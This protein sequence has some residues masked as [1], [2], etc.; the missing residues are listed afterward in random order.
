MIKF[1]FKTAWR[2]LVKNGVY[3]FINITGLATGLAVAMLVGLWIWDELSFNAY[4]QHHSRLAQVLLN[5]TANGETST[6]ETISMP[7]GEALRTLHAGD[8]KYVSLTSWNNEHT[9]SVENNKLPVAGRWVEPDF[10]EMFTLEM[11]N[12][13]RGV[14]K[15][16]STILIAESMAKALFGEENPINRTVRLD[17]KLDLKIG[18]VY[19]DLPHNSSFNDTKILLPWGNTENW[20]NKQTSWSN[21]CGLLYVLLNENTDYA[22]TN[23]KIKNIP[24]PH[25][26]KVKEEIMLHPFSKLNL[27]TE[28]ENGVATGGRI[29]FVWLFGI[30]GMFVLLLACINFINLSTARSEKRA[31]E[32][33][34]KKAVGSLRSQ[35]IS[36]FLWEAV[37]F[38]LIAF[39]LAL[40][41]V[42]LSLPY[43]NTLADKQIYLVSI[44]PW[45]LLLAL[46]VTILTGIVSGSYPA[47]YLSRFEPI[48]VLKGVF[49][50]G[51][52]ASLPRKVLVVVQFTVSVSLIIGT[53]VIFRQ[54][55]YA[56]DRPTGFSRAGLISIPLTEGLY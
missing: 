21:H 13:N 39:L 5:Q 55:E 40:V 51:R 49:T 42:Q 26:E 56:K 17:N 22:S 15:D 1:F 7:L 31:K 52:F 47:F 28:F 34:I 20:M 9:I 53:I 6:D 41:F 45:F 48:K 10:P 43:F 54:I 44:A 16:P 33:G 14:L 18:G 2:Q 36:Q 32:V 29:Q 37:L 27:Y 24:T 11:V 19:K 25:I 8:F 12:G 4:H 50:S 38:S 3:S 23:A 46:G 30:I 35:L